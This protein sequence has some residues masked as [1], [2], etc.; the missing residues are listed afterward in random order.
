V[1]YNAIIV[2]QL[3]TAAANKLGSNTGRFFKYELDGEDLTLHQ[4]DTSKCQ[5][6]QTAS[7]DPEACYD[8]SVLNGE[9]TIVKTSVTEQPQF[10]VPKQPGAVKVSIHFTRP[11]AVTSFLCCKRHN[12]VR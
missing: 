9:S 8:L 10:E 5:G 6:C 12:I 11:A 3:S 1:S 7:V 2:F 4:C